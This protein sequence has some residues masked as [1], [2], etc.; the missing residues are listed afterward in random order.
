MGCCSTCGRGRRPVRASLGRPE[1]ADVL[2]VEQARFG[3]AAGTGRSQRIHR[4]YARAHVV[5]LGARSGPGCLRWSPE[6]HLDKLESRVN[7][8]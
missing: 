7:Q 4:A 1:A 2:N 6:C 3:V 5:R 8:V